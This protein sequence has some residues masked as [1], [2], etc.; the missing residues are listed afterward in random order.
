MKQR[1]T[2]RSLSFLMAL[3]MLISLLAG[4]GTAAPLTTASSAAPAASS[5]A[6]A[7]AVASASAAPATPAAESVEITW[8]QHMDLATNNSWTT[9]NLPEM[10]KDYGFNVTFKVIEMG[11]HDGTEWYN[12]FKTMVAS[13]ENPPDIIHT[14]GLQIEAIDAGWY[15][16]LSLDKVKSLMP[17]YYENAIQTYDKILAYGRD[18]RDS[19]L[20]GLVSWN[21]FGPNRHT[22]VYRQDWLDKLEIAVPTTIEEFENF[23]RLCRKTDFNSNGVMDEYGYTS[24]TNSPFVGFNEVFAAYG[25]QPM[26]WLNIDGKMARGEVLPQAKEALAIMARW[27]AEDLI[28]KGVGTTE[29]RRDGF[30]QGIRGSYGQGDGYAPALVQGGQNYEEFKKMQPNGVMAVVPSFKGPRGEWGTQEWGPRKYTVGFGSQLAKDPEKFDMI[31]K[32]LETIATEEKL[33]VAGMLGEQG[34]HWDF[35]DPSKP[36][37]ATKFLEP[38]TEFNKRLDEVGVREMSESP[39]CP[40][41]VRDVYVKYLDP[42]AV[43]Y[44]AQN[45]G[46]FDA[47]MGIPFEAQRKYGGDLDALTKESFLNIIT[48]KQPID[49][50]DE[51]VKKWNLNG[52]EE[53]T[54]QANELYVKVFN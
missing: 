34:T 42:L 46:Y 51:Y 48:G 25:T 35:T 23:L 40:V 45:P 49:S 1:L 41:W 20:Y 10:L 38:F 18:S 50:F 24:G 54:K 39:F 17:K 6:A 3:L 44:S 37:G 26:A 27:Y 14:A 5:A 33:F 22:F 11:T 13:G 30:N 16:E 2:N 29:T 12:K 21:M 9:K 32:M 53:M 52:G 28:P 43:E 31:L 7:T 36:S 19:K 8:M 4:C 15:A 47:T